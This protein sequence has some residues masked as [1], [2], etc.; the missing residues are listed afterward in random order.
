MMYFTP[1]ENR[2]EDKNKEN[3][4]KEIW[5]EDV[6]W[7]H[8][9]QYRLQQWALVNTVTGFRLLNKDSAPRV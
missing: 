3:D 5:C 7:I 4:F 6:D 9:A 8:L 2:W 1:E